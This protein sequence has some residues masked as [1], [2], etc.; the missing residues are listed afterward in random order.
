MSFGGY[1][2]KIPSSDVETSIIGTDY[3]INCQVADL[4]EAVNSH[5]T[6]K[7]EKGIISCGGDTGNGRTNKC[8]LLTPNHKWTPFNSMNEGRAYF[9]M[10]EGNGKLFAVGGYRT[11]NSMEWIDL[12]SGTSWRRE[13]LPFDIRF[14]CMSGFNS[15]HAILTGG[16]LDG[17]VRKRN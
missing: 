13:N 14:H 4:P 17:K 1:F 11:D 15:T 8:H 16:V 9:A 10:V 3:N 12:Q 7:T 5:S 6:I 2:N